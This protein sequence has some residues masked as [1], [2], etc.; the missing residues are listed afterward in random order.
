MPENFVGDTLLKWYKENGRILPWRNTTNP[1]KI[2][3]AEIILQQTRVVQGLHYFNR[4]MERFPDIASL[5]EA[6]ED[7]VMKYWEGLGYY[8]R[9]RNL[10]I[11]AKDIVGRF[12]GVFPT[13]HVDILTLKGIGQYTAAA[14]SSFAHRAPYAVVDGNVYRVLSRLFA[15]DIPIDTTEGNKYFSSLAQTLLD[16]QHPDIYNQAIMDFGAMQCTPKSPVCATCPLQTHCLAYARN[17]VEQLPVKQG[18]TV[19]KPRYFN[20]LCIRS[21]GQ[22]LLSKRVASD[23]WQNLYE[24]PL[25]E[26]PAKMDMD[27][28]QMLP[29]YMRLFSGISDI[30]IKKVT[31]AP[32]HI[33][34]HRI[35]HASFYEIEVD[36]FSDEMTKTYLQIA[37]NELDNYAVSRL[38]SLYLVHPK[39]A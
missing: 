19:V 17:K 29:E 13:S 33:L 23:I 14:I 4:F 2:W 12:N 3:I 7:V 9:A 15:I 26:T 28:L 6:D 18:K 37:D 38:I 11:A 16:K 31:N 1:Y 8:S 35:I 22:L 25:L 5:A 32:K 20:Y 39:N 10:H 24:F 21:K 36:N 34:S 30:W 27:E